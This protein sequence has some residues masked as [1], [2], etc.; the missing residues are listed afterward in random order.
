MADSEIEFRSLYS[1]EKSVSNCLDKGTTLT[2][3]SHLLRLQS[4]STSVMNILLTQKNP[5]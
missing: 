4:I 1:K 3:T 5:W 2:L